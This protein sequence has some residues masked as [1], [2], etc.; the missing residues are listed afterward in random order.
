FIIFAVSLVILISIYALIGRKSTDGKRNLPPGGYGW[1]IIGESLDFFRDARNGEPQKFALS[2]VEKYKS[3]IFKTSL[4][5]EKM[6]FLSGASGNK[7]LFS[8]EN[9]LVSLWW[10]AS[11]RR[12][13][14]PCLSTTSG[15][16]GLAMRKFMS[17]FLNPERFSKVY[18]TTMDSVTQQHVR[19]HWEGKS[20][21]NVFKTAKFYTFELACRLFLSLDDS[22]GEIRRLFDLFNVFLKGIIS[23]D[24]NFPGFRF[25]AANRATLVIKQRLQN[26]VRNRKQM[27]E[28]G[29]RTDADAPQDLLTHLL[30]AC[31]ENGKFMAESMIVNNILML[32]FAGHDTSSSAITLVMKYLAELPQVYEDVLK[33]QEEIAGGKESGEFLRWEDIQKMR[34]TW[35]VV[36]E[37]IRL[38]PPVVGSFREALVDI[39]YGGYHIPKG[40]KL[41]WG[42]PSTHRDPD[43]FAECD[44]FDPS[45]FEGSGPV[46]Y[47]FVAFGGGPRMCL[48]KELARLE[49][50]IFLHNVVRRYEWRLKMGDERVVYDPMPTPIHGLDI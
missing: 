8:N 31:D 43:L 9:K 39:T 30:V 22:D 41:Y 12:L 7:F 17:H 5:G 4:L 10:P 45:R 32:L 44:R 36:S 42:A 26:I 27:L 50:L 46:P 40:W 37:V 34:Y 35:N 47:S 33:E 14:G 23:L 13:L 38:A 28:Q 48:G 15:E 29:T 16:E 20:E 25:H 2:R 21:V 11:V 3:P 24:F 1:P 49:I 6:A 19:N 18:I